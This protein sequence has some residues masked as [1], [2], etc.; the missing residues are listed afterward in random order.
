M[1]Q[2]PSTHFLI[3]LGLLVLNGLAYAAIYSA[4]IERGFTPSILLAARDL[5]IFLPI[6]GIFVWLVRR[7]RYAGDWTLLT[8][9]VLLFGM[10]QFVQYRLFTDP[11]YGAA[12]RQVIQA[13]REAKGNTL[14][15]QSINQYY[16]AA[17]K[18]ALFNDPDFRIPLR[19]EVAALAPVD[20]G[21]WT[22][23]RIA[24]SLS[25]LIPL[26]GLGCLVLAYRLTCR[27]L[28][29]IRLQ[30]HS[31]LL[32][33][34]TMLPFIVIAIFYSR[35]GKFLGNTTPWEPVKIT[36]LISYAGILA[37]HY[38]HLSRTRWGV[39][40][41]RFMLP[42][43]MIALMP[44]ASFFA[45]SDF[46]Q[47]LVFLGAYLTLYLVA[48]RRIPQLT[49]A[50]VLVL[51]LLGGAI[52][53]VGGYQRLTGGGVE[54]TTASAW[55]RVGGTLSQG[56]PRRIHQRIY[57]WLNGGIPPLPD[58]HWWWA[59]EPLNGKGG[60]TVGSAETG[61]G[62]NNEELWY[63]RYAYQPAQALF[64]ISDGRLL[65]KG[66]GRGYP[67]SVP[68][69]D[70]D[71]IYAAIAEEMGLLGG[72]IVLAA[73]LL[74]ILAGMRTAIGAPDMFTKLLAAGITC[75]LG[76]QAIVNVGGVIRML[77][78]TGIT[79]PFVSHGGWSLVTSFWMLG[80]LMAIS[81]RNQARSSL[82]PE[83]PQAMVSQGFKMV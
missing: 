59:N 83:G 3:L 11:E 54:M 17:K 61:A 23:E 46:G 36:F 22:L 58:E 27:D 6:L 40:P 28:V 43:L 62:F 42:F 25:T 50:A 12:K 24:T 49:M 30:R 2:R 81:H 1:R 8:A 74:L 47:M 73:L 64:G 48:V 37:D 60:E 72:G 70:S 21:Y 75:F 33:L 35:A 69:A 31:L 13:A 20:P 19:G 38:R 71:F 67:E 14:R 5:F 41:L 34:A 15:Q 77:P 45:L 63:N 52:L 66:L 4:G 65:G 80:M 16:D 10:G 9:A 79:L 51:V 78:M 57:L 55:E 53:G 26:L 39:P 76:L 32:G 44:V 29:L 56:V 18:R 68:I 82:M 7:Q